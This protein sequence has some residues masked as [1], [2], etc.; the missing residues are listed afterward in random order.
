VN[1]K[2]LIITATAMAIAIGVAAIGLHHALNSKTL[3]SIEKSASQVAP[4]A[5]NED[6][7]DLVKISKNS[8]IDKYPI[9]N[10]ILNT[11]KIS[12]LLPLLDKFLS[13][14]N[15]QEIIQ[16]ASF[17]SQTNLSAAHYE[18]INLATIKHWSKLSALNALTFSQTQFSEPIRLKA[19]STVLV[20]HCENSGAIKLCI[21]ELPYSNHIHNSLIAISQKALSEN[22]FSK[23]LLWAN[24]IQESDK[25]EMQISR[26]TKDWI[27]TN[28]EEAF[29]WASS[30]DGFSDVAKQA[31]KKVLETDPWQA[32]SLV[33]QTSDIHSEKR[34]QLYTVL[35]NTLVEAEDF[36]TMMSI[37]ES[38]SQHETITKVARK[39]IDKDP[40]SALQWALTYEGFHSLGLRAID[41]L[42]KTDHQQAFEIAS[43]IPNNRQG[44]RRDM[45][46]S[47]FSDRAQNDDFTTIMQLINQLPKQ[48]KA[49]DY[50]DNFITL[51]AWQDPES[52]AD[53]V[54][55]LPASTKKS[56]FVINTLKA[57]AEK[58]P[59]DALAAIGQL[60]DKVTQNNAT[61]GVL[62]GWA[63]KDI[64]AALNWLSSQTSS[65]ELDNSIATASGQ[66]LR[67]RE[68]KNVMRRLAEKIEDEKLRESTLNTIENHV[69]SE[70]DF[71]LENE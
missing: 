49:E 70:L 56:S 63:N 17:F 33:T 4:S 40:K 60:N 71:D 38:A 11:T 30:N 15:Q 23:A 47:I 1:K 34:S 3:P 50:Y 43:L 18:T 8:I 12:T 13:N 67:T 25:R 64:D 45:L 54:L 22:L 32:Y 59:K 53:A 6:V 26:I 69:F 27:A 57:W 37:L 68:D 9:I 36:L 2:N 14:L 5:Q 42:T 7:F 55:K 46:N 48:E 39:W 58:D 41:E 29:L 28:A 52:A 24:P 19:I 65:A 35:V 44:L 16:V 66:L 31:I 61:T 20:T 62:Q 21:A 51:W 10:D